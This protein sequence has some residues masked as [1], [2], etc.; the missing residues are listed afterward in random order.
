MIAARWPGKCPACGDR[1]EVGAQIKPTE[2]GDWIHET[3][4]E[5]RRPVVV[6]TETCT[7]CWLKKSLDGSCGCD[8]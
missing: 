4:D 3:C 2:D 7:R 6:E 5:P 8:A 1:W